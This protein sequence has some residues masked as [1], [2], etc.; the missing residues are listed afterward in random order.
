MRTIDPELQARLD[1]RATTFCRCW[2]VLRRDGVAFGFTD[3]DRD[4]AFEGTLF[5]ASSGMDTTTLQLATGLSVDNAQARGALSDASVREEDIRAGRFD[6]AEIWHWLADWERPELRV[7]LFRGRFGEIRRSGG[8]YEVELRGPAE[9]LNA[10]VGRTIMKSCDRA[11]G[12]ASC[13]FDISRPGFSGEGVALA[14]SSGATVVASGL[15]GFADGWFV[16]GRA[17]WLSGANEG[18]SATVKADRLAGDGRRHL[19]LWQEPGFDVV[20]GDRFRLVAGCDKAAATC[21]DK[22][23]NFINFRGFP[24]IPGDDWVTAYPTNGGNHDGGR[25]EG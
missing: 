16:Q 8:A 9:T 12:D 11:L 14:G 5:R 24:H 2:R 23:M 17:T 6:D 21:R 15:A 4:L 7:L 1:G 20:A 10:P 3:H 19:A 18:E 13:G 25:R 22:F